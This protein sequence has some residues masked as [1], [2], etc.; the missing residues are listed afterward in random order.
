[1]KSYHNS[2]GVPRCEFIWGGG[3]K[4]IISAAT[5]HI[6]PKLLQPGVYGRFHALLLQLST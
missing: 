2:V 6:M 5:D 4:G 3:P 1:M